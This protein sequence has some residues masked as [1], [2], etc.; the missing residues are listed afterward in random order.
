MSFSGAN[1]SSTPLL[2]PSSPTPLLSLYHSCSSKAIEAAI[3]ARQWK[4]VHILEL[5][6]DRSGGKYYLKIAQY[7]ASIQ[8]YEVRGG[9]EGEKR[10]LIPTVPM[11]QGPCNMAA[12][13]ACLF[14]T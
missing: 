4:A 2:S 7:Y 14:Q 3:G 5:Q 6:E 1:A 10:S 8:E 13:D 11:S 9:R 12:G